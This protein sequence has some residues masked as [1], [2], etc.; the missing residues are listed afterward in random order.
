MEDL[1]NK[2]IEIATKAHATQLD[3]GGK[4][5]IEHPLR[6]MK[7]VNTT[8]EK[9]VAI[10]HDVIEDSHDITLDN[11][12]ELGFSENVVAAI[13]AISKRS[14]EKYSHYLQRVIKEPIALTVKIADMTDNM[15]LSRIANPTDQDYQR[16]KKYQKNISKLQKISNSL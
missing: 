10:L 13:D 8:E 16:A 6:V 1:L 2:A 15:D 3:K 5:Y 12:I 9:I 11:L 7:N 4:P 14:G